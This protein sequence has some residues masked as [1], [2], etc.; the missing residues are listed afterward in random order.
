MR[1]RVE[2]RLKR[3]PNAS[4]V[5]ALAGRTWAATGDAPKGEEFL[6]RAIDADPSNLDVDGELAGLYVAQ[7]KLDQAVAEFSRLFTRQLG[8]VGP[9][10][11]AA[12]IVQG[13]GNEAEARRR[14]ERLVEANPRA[15]VAANNLAW[16]YASRGEELDKA[17]QLAE[18]AEAEL[19]DHPEVN[20]TLGFVYL[21]KQLPSLAVP[22]LR[23]AVRGP[24]PTG[25]ST[26]TWDW[27]I[28]R[29][30]TRRRRGGSWSTR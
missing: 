9:P 29:T 11:L 17:L 3:T 15:A 20:D 2:Q 4:P 19:P 5:L 28:R 21:K 25:C 27:R 8:G 13:Q 26:T 18:T 23:L 30:A 10:T 24:R 7:R 12:M 1:A 6:R 14:D 16:I 22:P